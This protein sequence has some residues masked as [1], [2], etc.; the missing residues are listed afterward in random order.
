MPKKI[1]CLVFLQLLSP[2][3]SIRHGP[4]LGYVS[5][6][7]SALTIFL[8]YVSIEVLLTVLTI[9]YRSIINCTHHI[10]ERQVF[11]YPPNPMFKHTLVSFSLFGNI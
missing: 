10:R 5:R 4:L 3:T 1:T 6:S 11:Y 9:Y 2:A 8:E 7:I